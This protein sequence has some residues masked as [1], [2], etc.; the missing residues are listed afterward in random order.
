MIA[1][2]SAVIVMLVPPALIMAEFALAY[3]KRVMPTNLTV[4]PGRRAERSSVDLPGT[5]IPSRTMEVQAAVAAGM[6]GN[7][8][9]EQAL[10]LA[11]DLK[12]DMLLELL[13]RLV[14]DRDE[15]AVVE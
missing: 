14:E 3:S 12:D 13:P 15:M 7:A 6:A 10:L 8:V 11:V 1:S 2:G 9:T 5:V 4:V